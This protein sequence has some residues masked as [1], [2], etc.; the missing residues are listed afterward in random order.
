LRTNHFEERKDD[1]IPPSMAKH[2]NEVIKSSLQGE[3]NHFSLG[4]TCFGR[5]LQ[6]GIF[7]PCIKGQVV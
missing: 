1:D 6:L 2:F 4:A 5:L 7:K 3:A